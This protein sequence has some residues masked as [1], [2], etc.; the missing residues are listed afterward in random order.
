MIDGER[1]T[2]LDDPCEFAGPEGVRECQ[3]D[4]LVLHMGGTRT[5]SESVLRV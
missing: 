2:G 5:S 1:V 4:D 3:V